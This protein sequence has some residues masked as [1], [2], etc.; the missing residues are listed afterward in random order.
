MRVT[1]TDG[2]ESLG[3]VTISGVPAGFSLSAG[4]QTYPGVWFVSQS[5]LAGLQLNTPLHYVG[6]F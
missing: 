5:D 2:S 6:K 4:T 3:N 1:D